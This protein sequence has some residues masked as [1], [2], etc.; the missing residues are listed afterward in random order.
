M[1][2]VDR[3]S[4]T[5]RALLLAS[6]RVFCRVTGAFH[7]DILWVIIHYRGWPEVLI[8]TL[9][10]VVVRIIADKI[11]ALLRLGRCCRSGSGASQCLR[12]ENIK[13]S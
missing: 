7:V 12:G 10:E 8:V 9:L 11:A 4:C 13:R 3:Q 6:R 5:T 1:V 2:I